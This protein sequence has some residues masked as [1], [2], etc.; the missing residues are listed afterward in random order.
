M[1]SPPELASGCLT[2]RFS[3]YMLR[4]QKSMTERFGHSD[5][6]EQMGSGD[7]FN[8]CGTGTIE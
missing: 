1:V 2:E 7:H 4:L 5:V 6:I 3:Q 8:G